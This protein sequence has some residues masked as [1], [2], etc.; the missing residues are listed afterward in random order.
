MKGLSSPL[1]TA[2][3]ART[4]ASRGRHVE[5]L[6]AQFRMA[7]FMGVLVKEPA[8]SSV[9]IEVGSDPAKT[10]AGTASGVA[11]PDRSPLSSSRHGSAAAGTEQDW[12]GTI[13]VRA[14]G[15]AWPPRAAH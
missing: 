4:T 2:E 14:A 5:K 8:R 6:W 10:V 1:A 13:S 7:V 3:G 15:A 9:D 12:P 11:L